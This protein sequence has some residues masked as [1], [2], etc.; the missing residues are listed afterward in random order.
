MNRTANTVVIGGGI[1]GTAVAAFL[2]EKM[3]KVILIERHGISSQASGSNY[4]M[5]W[6][7]PRT[8]GFE[9]TI[10][11]RSQELYDNLIA[12]EFDIDIEYEKVGGLTVGFTEAQN[13]AIELYCQRKQEDGIPVQKIDGNIV[14]ELEPNLSKDIT[15][16]IYCEQDAQLNPYLTTMAFS[17]LARRRGAEIM[18]ET[19]VVG[20]NSKYGKIYSID[21][22]KGTIFTDVVVCCA[23]CWSRKIAATA[24]VDIPIYPQRLQSLVTEPLEKLL[25]RTIQGARDLS[26]EDAIEHPEYALDFDFEISGDTEE[27]LPKIEVEDSIF[28]FI[29]PTLSGTVVLG[30]T[31]EFVGFDKRTTPRGMSA[32][33]KEVTKICPILK[34]AKIIRTWAGLIPYTFDSRPILGKVEEVGGLYIA[35]GHPHAF[36]HAPTVGEILT[37]LIT[38]EKLLDDRASMILNYAAINRF[39]EKRRDKSDT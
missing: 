15:S 8:P 39:K 10:A 4:G 22:S 1:I 9:I 30:T 28:A 5:V 6:I 37:T 16:A 13:K 36:S 31:N 32:I 7:Q 11:R 33:I 20:I 19:E 26:D 3:D 27:D 35:A 24:G 2:A 34:N 12:N 23:G 14:K 21:T 29:K 25:T 38:D 17:N 18:T